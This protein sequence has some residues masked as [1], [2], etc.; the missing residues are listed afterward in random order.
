MLA[1]QLRA[2]FQGEKPLICFGK[3]KVAYKL[4]THL[5]YGQQLHLRSFCNGNENTVSSQRHADVRRPLLLI[6]RS[7]NNANAPQR[8]VNLIP[9]VYIQ[10]WNTTLYNQNQTLQQGWTSQGEGNVTH[11]NIKPSDFI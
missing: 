4:S 2:S 7:G 11:E 8:T 1:S 3:L 9:T 6:S 10:Q 5:L